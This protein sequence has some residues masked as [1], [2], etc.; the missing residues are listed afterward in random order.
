[1]AQSSSTYAAEE[2]GLFHNEE[3]FNKYIISR[4][5]P[6]LLD[7]FRTT[8]RA[9][10]CAYHKITFT[11]GDIAPRNIMVDDEGDITGILD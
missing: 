5:P 4:L 2:A 11:H 10:S 9:T 7:T 8:T 3:L 1:M 6:K